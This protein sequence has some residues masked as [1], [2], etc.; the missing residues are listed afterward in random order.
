MRPIE[1]RVWHKPTQQMHYVSSIDFDQQEIIPRLPEGATEEQL[2]Y[3]NDNPLKFEDCELMQFTGLLDSQG[4]KIWESDI[5]AYEFEEKDDQGDERQYEYHIEVEFEHGC[6]FYQDEPLYNSVSVVT[7]G[8]F[9]MPVIGNKWQQ[10]L[11][12]STPEAVQP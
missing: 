8:T 10:P 9:D 11:L 6:F 2:D 12:L 1:F 5:L 4:T 3:A 7:D